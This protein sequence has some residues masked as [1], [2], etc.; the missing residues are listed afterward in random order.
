M[1]PHGFCLL[2]LPE[3]LWLH[4]V[5]DVLIGL[6]FF[7][8]PL[9]LARLTLRRSDVQFS[10]LLVMF[11]VFVLACGMTHFMDAWV[12]WFPNYQIQGVIKALS[13]VLAISTALV[14]WHYM[15]EL[16][17][18]PTSRQLARAHSDRQDVVTRLENTTD[19][20][21]RLIDAVRDYA[22][23]MMDTDGRITTWNSGAALIKGYSAEEVIGTNYARFFSE[24]DRRNNVPEY[25]LQRTAEDGR[26]ESEGWRLRKDGSW[27]W[28]NAVMDAI[29]DENGKLTGF[30]KITR[31]I[32]ERRNAAAAVEQLNTALAQSQKMEA[33]GQLTGGIAHDFNN[34]LAAIQGSYELLEMHLTDLN[35]E[36]RRLM[37]VIKRASERGATLTSRLLA[38]SR[39]QTLDPREVDLNKVVF[40]LSE[41]LRR[42][43]GE[44]VKI[45]TVLGGG[46]WKACVDQNQL[47]TSI[48]N[49][50]INARDAMPDGGKLTIE[51]SNA[52]LDHDY[53]EM[54]EE[55]HEGQYVVVAITDNGIGMSQ[56]VINHVFEPFYTTKEK[57]KGTGL[58][59]SQVF[60]FVKQSGGHLKLYSEPNSGTTVKMYFPRHFGRA[61]HHEEPAPRCEP[62]QARGE[63]VLV[64][65]DDADVQ[66]FSAVALQQLG[67]KVLLANT[68]DIALDILET[69]HVDMLFTDVGL[70]G[71][72]GKALADEA[73]RRKPDLKVLYTTGYARNAIVHNGT[74]D[75]GVALLP[76]PFTMTRL[77]EMC[78]RVLDGSP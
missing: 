15:P 54:H 70:P 21:R 26:F 23:Y 71:M 20:F 34:L 41:L 66:L 42:T 60:G 7:A 8:I 38:F 12:V 22:I 50:A 53:A 77:A 73:A 25:G 59:L 67:Y 5:S 35:D 46:L 19:M 62:K 17:S 4:V 51:T 65:E 49:I 14:L 2:W 76:K 27:F 10:W 64:V 61:D 24:E 48:L 45:E 40:G 68:A 6:A 29:Y 63:T 36:D 28:A 1:L 39:K 57:G 72:N 55:V 52:Y 13:A 33:I 43:L 58:G 69:E 75:A 31:D 78:R 16:E 74:L 18:F 47:E 56:E 37:G 30:A 3:V 32:T 11:A 9:A 44:Q